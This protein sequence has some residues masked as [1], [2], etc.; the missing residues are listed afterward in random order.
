MSLWKTSHK[1]TKFPNILKYSSV[2]PANFR[3]KNTILCDR[4]EEFETYK[5]PQET[6]L[7]HRRHCT[8]KKSFGQIQ[9]VVKRVVSAFWYSH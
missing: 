1:F 2:L 7:K 6:S 5:I 4:Q 8:G 9:Y 3:Y